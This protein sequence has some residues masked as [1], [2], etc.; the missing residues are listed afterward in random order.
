MNISGFDE[1]KV[2]GG[3]ILCVIKEWKDKKELCD[4]GKMGCCLLF[5]FFYKFS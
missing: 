1:G 5:F 3:W 4:I 2:D